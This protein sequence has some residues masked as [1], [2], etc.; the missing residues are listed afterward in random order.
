MILHKYITKTS[1]P[2]GVITKTQ[3]LITILLIQI[4]RITTQI[5]NL[6][7]PPPNTLPSTIKTIRTFLT[8][9]I[10]GVVTL[11]MNIVTKGMK[12]EHQTTSIISMIKEVI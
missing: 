11:P 9:K 7:H 3:D 2:E 5:P 10:G 8:V 1:Q 4:T 12:E 6:K